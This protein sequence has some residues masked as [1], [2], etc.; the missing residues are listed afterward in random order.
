MAA[1]IVGGMLA[2]PLIYVAGRL[3]WRLWSVTVPATLIY[4]AFG[5]FGDETLPVWW[6][7]KLS[8]SM[9]IRETLWF[10]VSNPVSLGIAGIAAAALAGWLA[11]FLFWWVRVRVGRALCHRGRARRI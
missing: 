11:V 8:V 10:L 9:W 5:A 3:Y 6:Q 7:A 4:V 1:A 2:I